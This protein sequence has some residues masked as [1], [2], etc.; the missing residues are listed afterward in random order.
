MFYERLRLLCKE[1]NTSVTTMLKE[2]NLS[3][4][5]TGYWKKGKLPNGEV[6]VQISE[7]LNTSI[8]YLIF[9][10]Y[11]TN[12]NEEQLH[13]LELYEAT[14]ERAKYKVVC[15]FEKIVNLEIEKF[16]TKKEAG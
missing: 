6:L 16:A 2:L 15:D 12:L 8:D 13:L 1:K 5:S 9:G 3:T 11:R 10:Q 7:Y 14:P 4:G